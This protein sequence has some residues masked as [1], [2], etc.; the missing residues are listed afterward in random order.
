MP[1]LPHTTIHT[2]LAVVLRCGPFAYTTNTTAH[3]HDAD[4]DE[5]LLQVAQQR[6]HLSTHRCLHAQ[7]L[8][9]G[10]VQLADGP[11]RGS[12]AKGMPNVRPSRTLVVVEARKHVVK[13]IN[14]ASNT[15]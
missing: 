6:L 2:H 8:T 14:C 12:D 11:A 4:A 3:L 13:Q 5:Q 7:L 1:Q 10:Q 9:G 15:K